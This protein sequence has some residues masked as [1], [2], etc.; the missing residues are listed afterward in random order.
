MYGNKVRKLVWNA[1]YGPTALPTVAAVHAHF[2]GSTPGVQRID[3]RTVDKM[4]GDFVQSGHWRAATLEE[5]Q[6]RRANVSRAGSMSALIVG[7][8]KSLVDSEPRLYLDEI[9]DYLYENGHYSP[10]STSKKWA[11]STVY[12]V[13]T[14][15]IKYTLTVLRRKAAEAS[16]AERLRYLQQVRDIPAECF[17]FVDE[18]HVDRS[19]VHRRRGWSPRGQSTEV[20]ESFGADVAYTLLA[21]ANIDGFLFTACQ[22]YEGK[23][24]GASLRPPPPPTRSPFRGAHPYESLSSR[25]DTAGDNFANWVEFRLCPLLGSFVL[26]ER[27]SVVVMDNASIHHAR[28]GRI[29]T[30]IRNAGARIIFLSPYSPHLN[31]IEDAFHQFKSY[32]RRNAIEARTDHSAVRER[33]LL[34]VTHANMLGYF[35]HAGYGVAHLRAA[36]YDA[37]AEEEAAAVAAAFAVCAVLFP[38]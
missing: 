8:I 34:N 16:L 35:A 10:Y 23:N 37:V 17:V 4:L 13:L 20:I 21:A 25:V 19:D 9:V 5:M 6:K 29:A 28:F 12:S 18:S 2:G 26:S 7:V 24:D 31:P 38:R 14:V 1:F 15:R 27:N 36:A 11:V 32:L 33:A 3:S 30:L 22:A